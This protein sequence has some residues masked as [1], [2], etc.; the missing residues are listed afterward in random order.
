MLMKTRK[1]INYIN[2]KSDLSLTEKQNFRD[3]F[4]GCK[5]R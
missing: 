5:K 1:S 2:S 4:Y 3:V